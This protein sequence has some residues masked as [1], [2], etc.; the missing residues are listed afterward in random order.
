MPD[1]L[2]TYRRK[3][4]F[5]K[6]SEPQGKK[7]SKGFSFVVQ[8]HAATRLHYDFRLELDGVLLSWAVTR[9]MSLDPAEKRL[10]V[11]TEDHP[12]EYGG[13]EGT[14]PK[15]Q[16]G[17]GT[18]MLWDRGTWEP[19][20]DPHAGLEEG[21]LHFIL[22]GERLKGGWALVRMKPRAKEKS[23]SWLLIKED[24]KEASRTEDILD[25]YT[26]SVATGRTMEEIAEGKKTGRSVWRSAVSAEGKLP[27]FRPVQLATLAD[28]AP[29]GKNWVHE[30]KYD[31]Y[32]GLLAI[33]G[34]RIVCYTRNRLD[35]TDRFASL[36]PAIE[37]IK[38]KSALIDGEVVAPGE[39]G[40]SDFGA[41]QK[42]L[43][44]G[45][46]LN[47]FAFDLL[48][49]DGRDMAPLPLLER[50][51]ALRK[52]VGK[53]VGDA[54]FYSEHI[55]GEGAE[56]LKA[57]CSAGGEGIVSKLADAP[58]TGGRTR[59]WLKIKCGN[60]QEFVIG[61]WAPS[62]RRTGFRSLLLGYYQGG[63]LIYAGRV[64]TGFNEETLQNLG[65]ELKRLERKSMPF[66]HVP[67][68]MAKGA[69]WAKPELV[70]EIVFAEFSHDGMVRQASFKGLRKDKPARD[71]RR[72]EPRKAPR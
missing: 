16:Y 39:G 26:T 18:V 67:R 11:R 68:E 48:E 54:I 63:D 60:A 47:Y 5:T 44:E 53:G 70:A 32:R 31:G 50:K 58:Y 61:G 69:R 41:L 56:V 4:D 8:K 59:G 2:E 72:E 12:I 57:V 43:S 45:L 23:E 6:T 55:E 9:G 10:A 17:G 15:G 51:D 62:T 33:G 25:E 20:H 36:V 28:E 3:R 37:R 38:V 24:D 7:K 29:K 71:V 64:G 40:R 66:K 34:G 35:W 65:R 21:M 14:I 27:K 19:L 1:Q 13:F 42:A 22:H 49:L 46:K 52:L 30:L